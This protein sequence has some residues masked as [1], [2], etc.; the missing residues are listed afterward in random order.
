MEMF[1]TLVASQT[2]TN[3]IVGATRSNQN[4]IESKISILTEKIQ[5]IEQKLLLLIPSGNQV[6]EIKTTVSYF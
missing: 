2:K 3:E 4:A 1:G 5:Q 6:R